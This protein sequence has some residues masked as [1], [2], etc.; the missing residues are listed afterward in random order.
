MPLG[1][2]LAAAWVDLLPLAEIAA[3]IQNSF[4]F[5]AAEVRDWPDRHRSHAGRVRCLLGTIEPAGA[6]VV[7]TAFPVSRRFYQG[8]RAGRRW[9]RPDAHWP[10]CVCCHLS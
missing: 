1:L 7:S 3:E 10:F 8:G 9:R 5:L 2:E 4:D 6:G